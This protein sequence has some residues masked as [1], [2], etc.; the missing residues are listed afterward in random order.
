MALPALFIALKAME[1]RVPGLAQIRISLPT[2]AHKGTA[3]C[4]C[5]LLGGGRRG[6]G[7]ETMHAHI[8]FCLV[9]RLN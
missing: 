6:G 1:D 8:N 9:Q 2:T 7:G 4:D 5:Q 3:N